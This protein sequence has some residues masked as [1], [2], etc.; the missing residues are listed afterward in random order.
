MRLIALCIGLAVFAQPTLAQVSGTS[1]NCGEINGQTKKDLE[2]V[3][4]FCEAVPKGAVVGAYATD[5]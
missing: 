2:N 4:A 3:R 1:P 5:S